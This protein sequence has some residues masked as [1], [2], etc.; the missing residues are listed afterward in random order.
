MRGQF[1]R[2]GLCGCLVMALAGWGCGPGN[3]VTTVTTPGSVCESIDECAQGG[4]YT[5]LDGCQA[6]VHS[7]DQQAA[8]S[9]CQSLYEAYFGCANSSFV[10]VGVTATFPG[11]DGPRNDLE[12][13]LNAAPTQ[14]ACA[15]YASQTAE[16]SDAG[17]A[18]P[19]PIPAACTLNLQCQAQCYLSN[20]SNL[21]APALT[22]LSAFGQCAQSCPT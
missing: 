13:C 4:S 20:V 17:L 22:E 7:L 12:A 1:R 10:C 19:P 9:G 5:W 6:Q 16:C 3:T 21:C 11:C 14:S 15:A 2:R 8:A 18:T